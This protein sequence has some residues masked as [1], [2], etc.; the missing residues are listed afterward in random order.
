M[1]ELALLVEAMYPTPYQVL[2][3]EN[4]LIDSNKRRGGTLQVIVGA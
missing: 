2:T 1:L 3:R 4:D